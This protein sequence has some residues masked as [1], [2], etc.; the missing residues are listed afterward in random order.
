MNKDYLENS[1]LAYPIKIDP[2]PVWF[3]DKLSTAM[4]IDTLSEQNIHG[5]ILTVAN[6]AGATGFGYISEYRTYLDT[7]MIVKGESS[8]YQPSNIFGRYIESALLS[9][10]EVGNEYPQGR[11]EI[12]KPQSVWDASTITW[13][14][15]PEIGELIASFESARAEGVR[16]NIDITEWAQ[17]LA[18]GRIKDTGMV[19][20]APQEHTGIMFR[21]PKTTN[22]EFMRLSIT[23]REMSNYDASI[24]IS[25]KYNE[26]SGKINIKVEDY[27]QSEQKTV[28]GYQVFK[29]DEKSDKFTRV[30]VKSDINEITE[31]EANEIKTSDFRICVCYDYDEAMPSNIVTLKRVDN[32]SKVV[33]EQISMDTDGDGIEDGYEIWDFKTKWNE[34]DADGNYILDSDGDGL[35]DAYEVFY[36]GSNPAVA[37]NFTEDSDGDSLSDIEEYRRGTD[38]HLADSDFDGINDLNDYG[39]TNP[40]KTDNPD[41]NE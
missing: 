19:L 16:H 11:I 15:Q 2:T 35:T 8:G 37:E 21:G 1:K 18:S 7:S 41:K 30:A 33:F 38:P 9:I 29:R 23:H 6:K 40:R 12:R 27:D 14:T 13:E 28:T 36:Q 32:I 10:G 17:D 3:N 31:I 4:V 25:A 5:D 22:R 20:I 24:R 26:Q 34:K 39:S